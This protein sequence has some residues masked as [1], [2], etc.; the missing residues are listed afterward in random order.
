VTRRANGT[1]DEHL[2][3]TSDLSRPQ[4]VEI[5]LPLSAQAEGERLIVRDGWKVWRPIIPANGKVELKYR[6][7]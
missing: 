6:W 4:Q 3:L 7:N 5:E 1:A 2:T